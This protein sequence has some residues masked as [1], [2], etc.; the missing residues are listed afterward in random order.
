MRN[1]VE[2][3]RRG[4]LQ[5]ERACDGGGGKRDL[6]S[7]PLLKQS[8][9]LPELR[10]AGGV[11]GCAGGAANHGSCGGKCITSCAG[12]AAQGV[13]AVRGIVQCLCWPEAEWQAAR[14][15]GNEA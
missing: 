10:C 7:Q 3:M 14:R 15:Q 8:A 2:P 13:L 9:P 4:M 12:L 5:I 11:S 1:L 6:D